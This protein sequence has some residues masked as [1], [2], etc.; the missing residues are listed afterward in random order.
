MLDHQLLTEMQ[1]DADAV[2]MLIGVHVRRE[3]FLLLVFRNSH[4]GIGHFED[5]FAGAFVNNHIHVYLAT[6]QCV[7]EGIRNDVIGHL[8]EMSMIEEHPIGRMAEMHLVID[9]LLLRHDKERRGDIAHKGNHIAFFKRQSELIALQF[10]ELHN[11]VG[12][13]AHTT[14]AAPHGQQRAACLGG[15]TRTLRQ[16]LLRTLDQTERRTEFVADAGKESHLELIQ[17]FGDLQLLTHSECL[18]YQVPDKESECQE[19]NQIEDISPPRLPQRRT[20]RHLQ[21][22]LGTIIPHTAIVG[23]THLKEVSAGLQ[24]FV[25]DILPGGRFTPIAIVAL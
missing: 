19:R 23:G 18:H 25:I 15:N 10:A 2:A 22:R 12:Q 8:V 3:Q 13:A 24:I 6:R 5:E 16:A 9:A 1:A 17:F 4:P 20:N 7:F 11:L 14:H 21:R